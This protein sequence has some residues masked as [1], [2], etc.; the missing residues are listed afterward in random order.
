VFVFVCLDTE[1]PS[2]LRRNAP[3][4]LLPP[5]DDCRERQ[6]YQFSGLANNADR[7]S[8]AGPINIDR[9]PRPTRAATNQNWSWF[10]FFSAILQYSKSWK[11]YS[12]CMLPCVTTDS[13]DW[14]MSAWYRVISEL[15]LWAKSLF[16]FKWNLIYSSTSPKFVVQN[17]KSDYCGSGV[18]KKSLLVALDD[19]LGSTVYL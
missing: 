7:L 9:Y 6:P 17:S 1:S 2:L 3:T 18:A 19:L 16:N 11:L 8:S 10:L 13:V 14:I 15:K 5:A 4:P 12:T